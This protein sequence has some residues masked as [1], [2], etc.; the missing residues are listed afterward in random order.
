MS[1]L[2]SISLILTIVFVPE[3]NKLG[4]VKIQ[5]LVPIRKI[6]S[7]RTLFSILVYRS[8]NAL[9]RGTIMSF[10]PLFA[11]QFLEVSGTSI[12]I[13]LSAGIYL[14]AFLQTPFGILA[15]RYERK[16]LL[17]LGG[18]VA[19]AGY[20]YMVYTRSVPEIFLARIIVSIGGAL[21]LPAVTAIIA[22][23]GREFGSF[24][25]VSVF[26]TAMSIGHIR[27]SPRLLWDELRILF[28]RAY[29]LR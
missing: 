25:T 5:T 22:E 12:G 21:S 17:V 4:V 29:K 6:L 19:T 20:T 16:K 9:G 14:N 28:L 13:I 24:S 7:N 18:L 1:I 26:S 11:V 27:L 10:L 8:V 2:I 15:D 23:E 3:E